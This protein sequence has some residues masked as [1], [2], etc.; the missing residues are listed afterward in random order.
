MKKVG[1]VIGGEQS[2]HIIFSNNGYSGDGILTSLFL[3]CIIKESNLKMSEISN[4]FKKIPQKLVNL[5]LKNWPDKILLDT[6]LKQKVNN[7]LLDKNYLTDILIRKSG[8]ENVLRIMVQ[9]ENEL[10]LNN[11][12]QDISNE[13]K[14]IDDQKK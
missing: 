9:C 14:S 10:K 12:I 2:G 6:K 1:A 4:L 8:T 3:L 11:I 5:K 13:V 7:Y